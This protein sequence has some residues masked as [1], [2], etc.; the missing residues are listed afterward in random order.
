M[1][2]GLLDESFQAVPENFLS[3][4]KTII[5]LT[6]LTQHIRIGNIFNEN[7]KTVLER[8]KVNETSIK[9]DISIIQML[10]YSFF[11]RQIS[12]HLKNID[13]ETFTQMFRKIFYLE[14]IN[15]YFLPSDVK[16]SLQNF[17]F[18][19]WFLFDF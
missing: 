2:V 14:S 13:Q 9:N 15:Y 1:A 6:C 10:T 11:I 4:L 18:S 3:F 17:V 19:I 7:I 12:N 8:E 16:F 5:D